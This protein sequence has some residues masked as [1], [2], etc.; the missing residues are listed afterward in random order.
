MSSALARIQEATKEL[1]LAEKNELAMYLWRETQT[2][3][4]KTK[5]HWQEEMKKRTARFD[6]GKTQFVSLE[7]FRKKYGHLEEDRTQ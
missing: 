2:I 5:A 1:D 7:D 3:P 6:E 4:P